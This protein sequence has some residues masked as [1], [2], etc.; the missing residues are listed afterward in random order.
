MMRR[1]SDDETKG[2]ETL[3]ILSQGVAMSQQPVKSTKCSGKGY[4]G[5]ERGHRTGSMAMQ[6]NRLV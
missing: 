6:L 5:D 2:V 4:P 3:R 1:E